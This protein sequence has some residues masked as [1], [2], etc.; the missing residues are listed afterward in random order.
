M[1]ARCECLQDS[2]HGWTSLGLIHEF[3]RVMLAS[4]AKTVP[5]RSRSRPSAYGTQWVTWV[6][7]LYLCLELSAQLSN[8]SPHPGYDRA[9]ELTCLPFF[10]WSFT[11]NHVSARIE[12][13]FQALALDEPRASFKPALWERIHGNQTNLK[14]VWFPGTHANVGGGFHDQQIS[15]ISLACEFLLDL[16]YLHPCGY[17]ETDHP[18]ATHRDVRPAVHRGRRV[19][20]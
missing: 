9:P 2:D 13:A 7:R 1:A 19:R 16:A 8:T 17:A 14:Q 6:Y 12:N 20:L 5:D 3:R 11:N 15:I 18:T 4:A 10:T